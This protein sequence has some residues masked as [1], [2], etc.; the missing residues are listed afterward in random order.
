[1][2]N[3]DYTDIKSSVSAVQEAAGFFRRI[4]IEVDHQ[5]LINTGVTTDDDTATVFLSVPAGFVIMGAG[6]KTNEAFDDAGGGSSLT[7]SIGSAA[8]PDDLMAAAQIHADGTTV[9][10]AWS[11]GADFND[12]TTDNVV[13]G[14]EVS[15]DTDY[16]VI[17]T[18]SSYNLSELT[19]GKVTA[20]IY[21]IYLNA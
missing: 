9:D 2:A 13:N 21:G 16:D 18:P 6:I 17:F 8:D 12:G 11:G 15:S 20:Y 7:V 3:T 4:S 5:D 1:M 10:Y 19:A 14:I